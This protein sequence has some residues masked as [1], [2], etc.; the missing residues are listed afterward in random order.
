VTANTKGVIVLVCV[1][2][3]G[4]MTGGAVVTLASRRALRTLLEAP[5]GVAR[6]RLLLQGLDR[7]VR[8]DPGQR[9]RARVIVRTHEA[10]IR[11]ANRECVPQARAIRGRM[12]K[13]LRALMREEQLDGF[14]RFSQRVEKVGRAAGPD[15]SAP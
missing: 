8:L 14:Q 6:Q 10:E 4:G 13:E 15:N 1:F 2:L 9:E 5:P 7:E 11:D 3:L 12:M